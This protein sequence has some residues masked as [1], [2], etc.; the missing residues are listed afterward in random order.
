ML[1]MVWMV[2]LHG[3]VGWWY[4]MWMLVWIIVVIMW[5]VMAKSWGRPGRQILPYKYPALVTTGNNRT[6]IFGDING[7][8]RSRS[9]QVR[10]MRCPPSLL[11]LFVLGVMIVIIVIV[12]LL[13][14]VRIIFVLVG[15]RS[16]RRLNRMHQPISSKVPNFYISILIA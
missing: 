7:L 8:N 12:V 16:R 9:F 5:I 11:C 3:W 13:L 14:I 2:I 15:Q 4:S 1:V 6:R 10:S